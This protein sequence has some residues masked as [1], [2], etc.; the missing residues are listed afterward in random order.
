MP[1]PAVPRAL[2]LVLF[3]AC[4]LPAA[5]A[6]AFNFPA[7]IAEAHRAWGADARELTELLHKLKAASA[8]AGRA[9]DA[10]NDARRALEKLTRE[11]REALDDLRNGAFCSGCGKTR[12]ELLARGESF[13]HP[14][15]QSRPA[16]PEELASAERDFAARMDI[17]RRLI[18]RYE[19]ELKDARAELDAAH[20]RFMVLL[21]VYHR[22]IDEE[23]QHRLG[24]WLDEKTAAEA[25][26]KAMH[27]AVAVATAKIKAMKDAD[28]AR[29]AQTEL[30]QLNRQLAQR[31][32]AGRIAGDRARSEERFFR[33]DV[34]ASLDS[35]GRIAEPIPDRFGI[36]GWFISKSI[37][38]PPKAVGYT[39]NAVYVG[40]PNG[41]V[42]APA[43]DLQRL[44]DGPGK[45]KPAKPGD[46]SVKDLLEGK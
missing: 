1:L 36:S 35:L 46:K 22:H 43:S 8:K 33:K 44:L 15:Q 6:T 38:N 4:L 29:P 26:L 14:G 31:L 17:Q 20:H 7:A 9:E 18:A 2:F 11:R 42:A 37:R 3:L 41:P 30:E 25:A 19:P 40:A 24:K 16:T 21:P 12:S 27:E 5:A 39:V 23:Q 10:L 13:P 32:A 28:Q 34:L 45:T